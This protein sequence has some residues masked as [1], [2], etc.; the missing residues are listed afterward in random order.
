MIRLRQFS[1]KPNRSKRFKKIET[2]AEPLELVKPN[3]TK[4]NIDSRLF[5][6]SL[7]SFEKGYSFLIYVSSFVFEWPKCKTNSNQNKGT[8]ACKSRHIFLVSI[9]N[10]SYKEHKVIDQ[11][12]PNILDTQYIYY[13]QYIPVLY[14]LTMDSLSSKRYWIRQIYNKTILN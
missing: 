9:V 2:R 4:Q 3:H 6:S 14:Y 12:T 1:Y 10:L 11:H 13:L 7:T 5:L 8:F